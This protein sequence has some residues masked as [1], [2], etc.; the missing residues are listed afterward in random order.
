LLLL[1]LLLVMSVL[2]LLPCLLICDSAVQH[3]RGRSSA[4]L[5][6]EDANLQSGNGDVIPR[7]DATSVQK[8]DNTDNLPAR[9]LVAT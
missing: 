9:D 2:T 1:L 3:H 8:L 6:E 7:T 4:L 5:F